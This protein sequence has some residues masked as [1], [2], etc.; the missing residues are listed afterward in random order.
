MREHMWDH[1]AGCFLAVRRDSLAKIDNPTMGGFTPLM[2]LV[3]TAAQAARMAET[4]GHSDWNTPLPIPTVSRSDKTFVSDG[5]W[6]GDTWPAPVYQVATGLAHYNLL[7]TST[8][9]AGASIANA[10]RV[11]ISEHYDS[12]SGK[13]LGVSGLGMSAVVL[14]MALDGL[15]P[16]H[17]ISVASSASS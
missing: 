14:T 7:D 17:R 1:D 8:R 11:G 13:P 3:P 15:S 2:A 10:V 12:L 16:A 4:L 9:L 5:F 6:R